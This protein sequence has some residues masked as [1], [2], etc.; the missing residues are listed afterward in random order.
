VREAENLAKW[1]SLTETNGKALIRLSQLLEQRGDAK[2]AA[3]ALD[4]AMYVNPFDPDLHRRL[5]T[6]AQAAGDKK[7]TVR[8]RAAIVAL[9]PVDK[10]DAL[11][12]LALAQHEA[13]DDKAARK[14]VLR[15][16]E[17]APNYEKAQTLL[18]TLYE[19]RHPSP[20]PEGRAP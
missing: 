10:A 5:A 15:A 14:S 18:L 2:G 8:E 1:T 6:L 4:R 12:Q 11:Y 20:E 16:L 3:E 13:G 17:E 9:G 19:A 7:A